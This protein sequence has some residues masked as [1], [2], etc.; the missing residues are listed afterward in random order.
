MANNLQSLEVAY[1]ADLDFI[2]V[3]GFVFAYIGGSGIIEGCAADLL[4]ERKRLKAEHIKVFTDI[5]KK[6]CAHALTADLDIADEIMQAEF[7]LVDGVIV[8][9]KFTGINPEKEDLIKARKATKLPILIG[10]GM[11]PESIKDYLPLADGFIV[12]TTF[13]KGNNF[14]EEIDE[15]RLKTFVTRFKEERNKFL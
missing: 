8:T 1:K 13:R 3:E 12:G 15:K 6:H 14:F 9:S 10:S 2:R 5:K 11:N 4:K 7:F